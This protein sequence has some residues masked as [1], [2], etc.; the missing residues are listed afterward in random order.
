M[1]IL[2]NLCKCGS[3]SLNRLANP[4]VS[5]IQLH[6]ALDLECRR[7]C[8]V[9]GNAN[10]HEP[11]LIW[12]DLIVDDLGTRQRGLAVEDFLGRG[13]LICDGPVVNECAAVC[14]ESM[15]RNVRTVVRYGFKVKHA[16]GKGFRASVHGEH[17]KRELRRIRTVVRYGFKVE[18]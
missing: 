4:T 17:C 9:A 15:V 13:C 10:E 7:I 2:A 11:F 3:M 18:T 16:K 12:G 14:F 5:A 8:C 1:A 6:S